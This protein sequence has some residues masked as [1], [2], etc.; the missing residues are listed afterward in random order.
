MCDGHEC[1]EIGSVE[2]QGK[3]Y[4]EDHADA[5]VFGIDPMD[6]DEFLYGF[7]SKRAQRKRPKAPKRPRAKKNKRLK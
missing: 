3:M 4:C 6:N 1:S 5:V 7:I 2:I